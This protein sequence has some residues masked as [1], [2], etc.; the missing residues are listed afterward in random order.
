MNTTDKK[1]RQKVLIVDDVT[2]NIQLVANFLKQAGYEIN[3]A[4]SGAKALKHMEKESFDL[5]LLDIMMPGLD[6]YEVTKTVK[7]D[8]ETRDIPIILVTALDSANDKA[9]GMAAGA[10]EFLNKPVNS[11]ED[12]LR[13]YQCV[14]VALK[15]HAIHGRALKQH[16]LHGFVVMVRMPRLVVCPLE[17]QPWAASAPV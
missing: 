7:N 4:V 6:G 11:A 8:P 17:K 1:Y 10:D 9:E 13:R 5:I 12:G 2:K 15:P 14:N 16:P 3:F